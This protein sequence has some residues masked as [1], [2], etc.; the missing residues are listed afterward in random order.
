MIFIAQ[1]KAGD[2]FQDAQTGTIY[3]VLADATKFKGQGTNMWYNMFDTC[4]VLD[5][6]TQCEFALEV[7]SHAHIIN[8]S[9]M[10]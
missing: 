9:E 1:L 3:E 2:R 8:R 7:D 5:T 6:E 10:L 4:Q